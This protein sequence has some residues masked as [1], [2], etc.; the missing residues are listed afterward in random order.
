MLRKNQVV[1][2]WL[3]MMICIPLLVHVGQAHIG[4]Q[5]GIPFRPPKFPSVLPHI[6]D[7]PGLLPPIFDK[8]IQK[9]W[10]S[11]WAVGGCV[12]QI[13]RTLAGFNLVH[14][15]PACCEAVSAIDEHC[16]PKMFPYAPFFPPWL[17]SNCARL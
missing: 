13:Q 5:P 6:P 7:L 17:K 14:I 15:A 3:V 16:W 1:S 10:S 2:S 11:L 4:P 8:D 9:C 12:R